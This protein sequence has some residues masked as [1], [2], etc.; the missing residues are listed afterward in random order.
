MK[1][2]KNDVQAARQR[3]AKAVT[4]LFQ[5]N[6]SDA[7]ID[8]LTARAFGTRT[9]AEAFVQADRPC[10]SV[11]IAANAGD[12]LA[13]V[14]DRAVL[15]ALHDRKIPFWV[16]VYEHKHGSDTVLY[17]DRMSAEKAEIAIAI[18]FWHDRQDSSAPDDP[19]G[20]DDQTIRAA[21][22]DGREDEFYST[23]ELVL[24]YPP[25][26]SDPVPPS[27][28]NTN[29][30]TDVPQDGAGHGYIVMNLA[31]SPALQRDDEAGIY[32]DD[33]EA[34]TACRLQALAG[35]AYA[36]SCL[37]LLAEAGNVWAVEI[38]VGELAADWADP[39]ALY[40]GAVHHGDDHRY[41]N[42]YHCEAC[43]ETW[44][45]AW[46]CGCD[47]TCPRCDAA[48]SPEE[49]TDLEAGLVD[50]RCDGRLLQ[51]VW[52]HPIQDPLREELFDATT[53]LLSLS[54][55]KVRCLSDSSPDARRLAQLHNDI[56]RSPENGEFVVVELETAI[57]KW[58]DLVR[59][60]LGITRSITDLTEPD[61]ARIRGLYGVPVAS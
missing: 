43:D 9:I 4:H 46:S 31:D 16:G 21:Y 27:A 14:T 8:A 60:R 10:G 34:R 24:S 19:S 55:E 17:P 56:G 49:T 40:R 35:D 41:L 6:A 2:S 23:Y 18:E 37:R 22:W 36:L 1:F 52:I 54:I 57:R 11:G 26:E 42:H 29:T 51:P 38:V 12:P 5:A 48:V 20:L 53:A 15:Q 32:A 50:L 45:D 7:Q 47:D 3:I 61:W 33:Q 30:A 39:D 44:E 58:L 13:G 28:E 59:T 25:Q